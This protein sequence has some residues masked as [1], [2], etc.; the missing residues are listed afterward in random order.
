MLGQL[1]KL[2][3]IKS[4]IFQFL[5]TMKII[6][7][8]VNHAKV[9]VNNSII[10]QINKGLLLFIGIS[11]EFSEEKLDPMVEKILKLRL[12]ESNQKG[13]D[14][15]IQDIQGE[16]LIVS[17]FTLHADCNKGNKPC[18]NKSAQYEIAQKIYNQFINKIKQS[19]LKT[20]TGQ[21]GAMMKVELEN[22]G[23]VTLIL[24]K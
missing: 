13:F 9:T 20:Q 18:F 12:W 6:L 8:R 14:L 5:K 3:T 21:F 16:I 1:K 7:Q 15:S 10:G 4:L 19:G 24:E 17:Q 23:P 2:E 11:K 22:D